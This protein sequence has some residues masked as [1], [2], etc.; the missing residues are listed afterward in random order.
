MIG[1]S[2]YSCCVN[3]PN[4]SL[5][6]I[7]TNWPC[8]AYLSVFWQNWTCHCY[9]IKKEE[10]LFNALTR[11]PGSLINN[12]STLVVM[13]LYYNDIK[14]FI[15]IDLANG[16][17]KLLRTLYEQCWKNT[18]IYNIMQSSVLAQSLTSGKVSLRNL[19]GNIYICFLLVNDIW[20]NYLQN[21]LTN[22]GHQIF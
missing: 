1:F 9:I 19:P 5:L 15:C 11:D 2:I 4:H 22:W 16:G 18:V 3:F 20:T 17:N 6:N 7:L 14:D 21:M 12:S 8:V 10:Y 13:P